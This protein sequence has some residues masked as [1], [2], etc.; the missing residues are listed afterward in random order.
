[1]STFATA[2]EGVK[3]RLKEWG[4]FFSKVFVAQ[5][6]EQLTLNQWVRGSS[7]REDTKQIS[8]KLS[9]PL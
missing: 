9:M 7:P 5:L 8:E 4:W 1:M 3:R 2:K 6:V